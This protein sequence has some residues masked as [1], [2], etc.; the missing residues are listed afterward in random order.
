[1]LS[2]TINMRCINYLKFLEDYKYY[3]S[4][5]MMAV[6][7]EFIDTIPS[8]ANDQLFSPKGVLGDSI[9]W[10]FL[11]YK[12]ADDAVEDWNRRRH[13]VNF[14]NNVALMIILTD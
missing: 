6:E 8:I 5:D 3:L 12:C 2:P 14:D 7:Q 4:I 1:M 11:H 9:Y 13:Y 10:E